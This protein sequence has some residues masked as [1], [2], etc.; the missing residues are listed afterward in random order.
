MLVPTELRTERLLLRPWRASDAA[1]LSP[2]LEANHAHLAPWIPAHVYLP[3]PAATLERRLRDFGNDFAAGREWRFALRTL[4]GGTLLGEVSLFARNGEGRTLVARAD[5]CEIGY[6]LR[7]DETGKG[8]AT[9]AARA[10]L[11]LASAEPRFAQ[12][13]IR[14]DARNLASSAVPRRLGFALAQTVD[15]ASYSGPPVHLQVW[16]SPL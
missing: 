10:M 1:D 3:A 12:V 9:E 2:I 15:D 5:R 13:E 8:F 14:C 4:E 11:A 7:R 6:W 16:S